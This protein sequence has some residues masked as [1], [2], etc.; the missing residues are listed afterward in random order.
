MTKP[1]I[2]TIVFLIGLYGCSAKDNSL[3][4]SFK[5]RNSFTNSSSLVENLLVNKDIAADSLIDITGQY[6]VGL[7]FGITDLDEDGYGDPYFLVNYSTAY[8]ASSKQHPNLEG[9]ITWHKIFPGMIRMIAHERG[10][11]YPEIPLVNQ[12]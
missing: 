3:P 8:W 5:T 11:K 1:L 10:D 12:K 4:E 2:K 7:G 6:N 9:E